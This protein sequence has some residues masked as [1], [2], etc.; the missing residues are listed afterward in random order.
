[1]GFLKNKKILITGISSKKSI[2]Y[3]IA[4]CMN[5]EGAELAFTYQNKKLKDRVKKI[6][7]KF[8]SNII[9]PCDVKEDY[10]IKYLFKKLSKIWKNFDGF[11]H[12]IA[13]ASKEQLKGDYIE[14]INRKD[15]L[16]SHEISSY[17][18]V[19][20]AKESKKMLNKN[21]SIITITYLGAE[22]VVQNYNIMGIAKASLEANTK[23]MANSLGSKFIRVNAISSGP[24]YTLA[25]SGIKDFKKMLKKN[26]LKSPIKKNITIKNIG[27][28]AS[29]L[30]SNL[31][32]G[33]TGEIIHVDGGFNILAIT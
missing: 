1:M 29:F 4:K 3:G 6:V 24:I 7:K 13:Y 21:S 19:S 8:N 18:F 9:L 10:Q 17:S 32:S 16:L 22:R 33:I 28:V 14:N 25:S 26:V 23:Y 11:V 5:R 20:L 31:S 27:N 15:F 30:I 12:S 2:S